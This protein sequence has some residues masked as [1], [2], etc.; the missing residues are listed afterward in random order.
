MCLPL[1]T[2]IHATYTIYEAKT[3]IWLPDFKKT[4]INNVSDL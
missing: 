1:I 2:V 3:P 4:L